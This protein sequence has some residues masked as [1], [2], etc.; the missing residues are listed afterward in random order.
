[1]GSTAG[2][3][4]KSSSLR[5]TSTRSSRW[6]E[7]NEHKLIRRLTPLALTNLF[8]NHPEACLQ[9]FNHESSV[10]LFLSVIE[11]KMVI[12]KYQMI[13]KLCN[14]YDYSDPKLFIA[15]MV[16]DDML[17]RRESGMVFTDFLEKCGHITRK[18]LVVALG[19]ENV[20]EFICSFKDVMSFLRVFTYHQ[21]FILGVI[22]EE[23]ICKYVRTAGETKQ[24]LAN[25]NAGGRECFESLI[26]KD[27]TFSERLCEQVQRHALQAT[28]SIFTEKNVRK[29]MRERVEVSRRNE[30][31][32]M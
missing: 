27:K 8:V 16:A 21:R 9:Y 25:L 2:L 3:L 32:R 19:K 11:K 1:M 15:R 7:K 18:R 24:V 26:K 30:M 28:C 20:R 31:G 12:E 5:F 14:R 23:K 4:K 10:K 29:E 6:S 13:F 17:Q 22:G